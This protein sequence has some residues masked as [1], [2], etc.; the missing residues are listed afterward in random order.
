MVE[1]KRVDHGIVDADVFNF[2]KTGFSIGNI[3]PSMVVTRA[4]WKGKA[5][6]TYPS[7]REWSTV[8]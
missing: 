3:T 2:D 6:S 8:N 1:E 7:N 5:K 4:D